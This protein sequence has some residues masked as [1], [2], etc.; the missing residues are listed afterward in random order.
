MSR[1][2]FHAIYPD[3]LDAATCEGYYGGRRIDSPDPGPN[4]HPAYIHGFIN[5]R[6]DIGVKHGQTAQQRREAWGYIAA[7]CSDD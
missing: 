7:A 3:P 2:D 1:P 4:R 6:D 5:G